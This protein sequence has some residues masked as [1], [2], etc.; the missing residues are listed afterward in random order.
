MNDVAGLK[1]VE[2]LLAG[3]RIAL[4]LSILGES[5]RSGQGDRFERVREGFIDFVPL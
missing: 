4:H 1:L 5:R 3:S 2:D